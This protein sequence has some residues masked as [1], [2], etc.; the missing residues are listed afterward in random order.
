M[1]NTFSVYCREYVNNQESL[2]AMFNTVSLTNDLVKPLES[3]RGKFISY[4]Q[5]T[6]ASN[7]MGSYNRAT[8]Y[9]AKDITSTRVEKEL[10]QDKGDSLSIDIMDQDEAQIEGGVVRLFNRYWLT[11]G[12]PSV[13]A[14]R[15]SVLNALSSNH[16]AHAS[17]TATNIVGFLLADKAELAQKRIKW[18]EC[19]VYIAV[20]EMSKLEEAS[21]GK[22]YLALGSFNGDLSATVRLLFG[23]AKVVEVPDDMLGSGIAWTIVHPLAIDAFVVYQEAEF[24]DKIAGYGKRKAQVDVG[25]Y[26]D[27]FVNPNGGDAVLSVY[28]AVPTPIIPA[29]ATWTG[30]SKKYEV[31]GIPEDASVFY[32]DDGNAP[33]SAST[34]YVPATGIVVTATK[35]IKV[36]QYVNGVAS[37]VADATYTKGN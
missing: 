26:H 14:Y 1:A 15:F 36:I 17:I 3:H 34:A 7:V 10:T 31:S 2:L 9:S 23:G 37:A 12:I 29:S 24:F 25:V 11:I 20:S 5:I 30:S 16:S 8:G 21:M 35:T 6:F 28:N 4:D 27:C 33:T 18:N 32:T 19:I 13:D 22:G